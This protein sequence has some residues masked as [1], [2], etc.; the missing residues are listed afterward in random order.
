MES[1][2]QTLKNNK[3]KPTDSIS[4]ILTI[5]LIHTY[6]NLRLESQLLRAAYFTFKSF[7]GIM[8]PVFIL[9]PTDANYYS[10]LQRTM[11]DLYFHSFSALDI[12][13]ELAIC[14][15]CFL[16]IVVEKICFFRKKMT[17]TIIVVL[18]MNLLAPILNPIFIQ[19][20]LR[21]RM[22]GDPLCYLVKVLAGLNVGLIL[23]D[24]IYFEV[25]LFTF[26]LDSRNKL[27][28]IKNKLISA[29]GIMVIILSIVVPPISNANKTV[30]GVLELVY[31][32]MPV[33]TLCTCPYI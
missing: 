17:A 14:G 2:N 33:L 20:M 18:L 22:G 1:I 19:L 9:F 28:R 16:L 25:F 6:N 3:P 13:T 12:S 8:L 23:L 21:P 27:C 30:A 29:R 10:D 7:I 5:Q 15:A 4:T 11:G 31:F 24:A 26:S 32:T